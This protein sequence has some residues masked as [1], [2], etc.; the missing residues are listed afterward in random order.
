MTYSCP[1]GVAIITM[2][3]GKA[4]AMS[5]PMVTAINTALDQ[6]EA[7]GAVVVL[8]GR[9]GRF[10]G[11]FDLGILNAGGPDAIAMLHAGFELTARIFSF[12]LPVVIACTGHAVALGAFLV[13]SGDYRIGADG[14]YKITANEVAIGMTVPR[15]AIELCRQRLAPA[16]FQR[17]VILAEVYAPADAVTAG[18]LDRVMPPGE[19]LAAA[20]VTATA[21]TQ[22]D[23]KAH[24]ATK[25]LARAEAIAI[26]RAEIA[27]DFAG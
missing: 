13:L 22:L 14:P 15:V 21:L 4:N 19:V 7:D 26:I 1:D 5:L 18:F 16:H 25:A 10:S 20:H 11:G 12:P 27:T 6:A 8:A 24:A 17:A 9:A 23:F 2:D 3:D